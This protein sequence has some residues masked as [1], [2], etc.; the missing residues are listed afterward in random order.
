MLVYTALEE[1]V[2]IIEVLSI[3]IIDVLLSQSCLVCT[4]VYTTLGKIVDV[5]EVI[6]ISSTDT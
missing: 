5:T 3:S 6:G 2:T 1:K 4:L